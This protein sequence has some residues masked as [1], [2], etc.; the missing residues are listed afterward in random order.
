MV[1]VVLLLLL[2]QF[3]KRIGLT[4]WSEQS[5]VTEALSRV[6]KLSDPPCVSQGYSKILERPASALNAGLW[7][8]L[9]SACK[10]SIV[11]KSKISTR[12]ELLQN[13]YMAIVWAIR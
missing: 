13:E 1:S 12:T 8:T 9:F 7:M 2:G 4:S 6:K 10:G 5:P 11:F 3:V